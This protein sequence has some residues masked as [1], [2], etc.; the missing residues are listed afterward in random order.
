[1]QAAFAW[2]PADQSEFQIRYREFIRHYALKFGK[3]VDGW[4]YDGCY[5]WDEFHNSL[6]EF[7]E[8]IA[9]SQA[10][11]PD[12]IVAFNDGSFCINKV[13]PVTL[14]EHYHAGEVHMLVDGKIKLGHDDDSPLYLP[15][16]RF[17]DGVQWHAL[18]PVDSTFEGGEPH[19]YSDAELIG[20]V[21][22]CKSVGGAVTL[23]LPISGDGKVPDDSI[24]Q[25]QRLG[26][27]LAR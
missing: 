25:M 27:A 11:N 3:L 2:S 26:A 23:N 9:A 1:V 15:E 10:G 5:E 12:A 8:W 20:F 16:S 13:P 19:E 6:Y 24:A 17:I 4:W 7:P 21:E 22:A 18:V 14:L